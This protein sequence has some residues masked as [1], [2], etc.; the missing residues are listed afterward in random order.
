MRFAQ[1][2]TLRHGQAISMQMYA[3]PQEALETV[4]LSE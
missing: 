1:V 2:W 4:G 3:S